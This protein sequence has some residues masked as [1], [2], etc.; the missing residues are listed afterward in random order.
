MKSL[1]AFNQTKVDSPHTDP[2][3]LVV[4]EFTNVTVQLCDRKF[5]SAGSYYKF[6]GNV[7][8]PLVEEWGDIRSSLIK[9][10]G[11]PPDPS[12]ASFDIDNTVP[13]AGASRFTKLFT[14]NPPHFAPIT[15]YNIFEGASSSSDMIIEFKGYIEDV[16]MSP[17][18]VHIFASGPETYLL[19]KFQGTICNLDDYPDADPDDLGKLIPISY[20]S[21]KK[22]RFT[23]VD[24]GQLDVLTTEIDSSIVSIPLSD[25]TGFPA[26][27]GTVQ[28]DQEQITY[29]A[30]SS[31]ILVGCTRGVNSTTA[32]AHGEGSTVAELQSAYIYI[33]DHAVNE[34]IAVYVQN[35]EN[36]E[37]YMRQEGNY[38]AYTGQTGDEYAGYEGK[39]VI[40]FNTLPSIDKQVNIDVDEDLAVDDPGHYNIDVTSSYISMNFDKVENIAGVNVSKERFADGSLGESGYLNGQGYQVKLTRKMGFEGANGYPTKVRMCADITFLDSS[41]WVELNFVM[42]GMNVTKT[43]TS[44]QTYYGGWNTIQDAYQSWADV[45]A[46]SYYLKRTGSGPGVAL[47][48]EAWIEIWW[49][50][51]SRPAGVSKT[52]NVWLTGNSLADTVIGGDV[53]ADIKAHQADASGDYGSEGSVV[54]RPDYIIKHF[55]VNYCQW[56]VSDVG[57]SFD[58]A[59][60]QY[61][62]NNMVLSPVLEEF[63]ENPLEFISKIAFEAKSVFYFNEGKAQ[64]KYLS[65]VSLADKTVLDI[66]IDE[67]TVKTRYTKRADIINKYVGLYNKEWVRGD[68]K[69]SLRSV[70]TI[71]DTDSQ[72]I[73]GVL[74]KEIELPFIIGEAQA[75][76]V[77]GWLIGIT[78]D[79][80][81]VIEMESGGYLSDVE[82]ADVLDFSF[83]SG[84]SLDIDLLQ[85][86]TS[87][88]TLFR[89]VRVGNDKEKNI[90]LDLRQVALSN[91]VLGGDEEVAS[92][93][94]SADDGY[95]IY[96]GASC[97]TFN[98]SSIDLYLGGDLSGTNYKGFF[99]FPSIQI[100]NAATIVSAYLKFETYSDWGGNPSF[101]IKFNDVDNAVVPT[102]CTE[103]D[104]LS[105]T[106]GTVWPDINSW[107]TYGSVN[108]VDISNEIQTIIDRAGWT[109]GNALLAIIEQSIGTDWRRIF[110]NDAEPGSSGPELHITYVSPWYSLYDNTRWEPAQ[111]DES[112]AIETSWDSGNSRWN[113]NIHATADGGKLRA[114]GS[115]MAGYK[116]ER[117]RITH[118]HSGT[119]PN[120]EIWCDN[121][122]L[123]QYNNYPSGTVIYPNWAGRNDLSYFTLTVDAADN[124]LFHVTNVELWKTAPSQTQTTT[125]TASTTSTTGS[126]V[127]TMSGSTTA[128]TTSSTVSTTSSTTSTASTSSTGSTFTTSF[129]TTS[130]TEPGAT[131]HSTTSSSSSTASTTHTTT[132]SSSKVVHLLPYLLYLPH[133]LCLPHLLQ[134]Q[135]LLLILLLHLA[136]QQQL[137]VQQHLHQVLHQLHQP[138]HHLKI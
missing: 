113:F 28:I 38:D 111:L 75:S 108:S 33:L 7:Y 60:E 9:F 36:K 95:A 59:G 53:C 96:S 32:V 89:V 42:G 88:S 56:S 23:A 17:Q 40:K 116:P 64:L 15:I 86:V 68:N 129:S 137:P 31:N 131:T 105:L 80:L 132:S 4:I 109:Q 92:P 41:C 20:G 61:R 72:A 85:L 97:I 98:P 26:G 12:E 70:S 10:D 71:S 35:R 130:S 27:G 112:D 93:G 30:V 73:Y 125:S 29:T 77:L 90:K 118:D 121:G 133:L 18:I 3:R 47:L 124:D 2:I 107:V 100:P 135:E 103:L 99:R 114:I 127:S 22:I 74:E 21:I 39:A 62:I 43:L 55:L 122:R 45:K 57:S 49:E 76:E 63:L 69:E 102:N 84:S 94:V 48:S 24:A 110:S 67:N 123:V 50:I 104:A 51:D 138:H 14:E 115:W 58:T 81:L 54:E 79:P 34:I 13:V 87:D 16:E 101:I 25:G 65:D 136:R 119:D 6:D 120:L 83:D 66:R 82:I 117:I 19:K 11:T 5:G 44:V 1:S 134:N 46:A 37:E 106:S 128:S 52:G 91:S 8:E 78:K 126:T